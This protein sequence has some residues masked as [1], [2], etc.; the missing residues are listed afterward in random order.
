LINVLVVAAIVLVGAAAPN[1][2]QAVRVRRWEYRVERTGD[3]T[4]TMR[5]N[6]LGRQ[7]WELVS[8]TFRGDINATNGLYFKRPLP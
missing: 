8:V 4:D 7:G 1:A 5:L 2:R 6:V 3:L